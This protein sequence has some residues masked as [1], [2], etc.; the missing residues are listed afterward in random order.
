MPAGMYPPAAAVRAVREYRVPAVAVYSYF[1]FFLFS[2]F[3][4]AGVV[5]TWFKLSSLPIQP[6]MFAL[7]CAIVIPFTR[8]KPTH[9]YFVGAWIFWIIFTVGGFLGPHPLAG[10]SDK[11]LWELVIKL[12]ISLVGVPY[13]TIRAIDR[14]KLSVLVKVAVLAAVV[15]SLFSMLQVVRPGPFA[16]LMAE[17][18]RGAGFWVNPNSC[19][20][21]VG[22]CL[23]LSLAF[24]FKSKLVNLSVRGILALGVLSTLSRTGLLMLVIGFA[25]YG[26]AAKRVRTVV[27]VGLVLLGV[28][29]V[30]SVMV[31]YL[32]SSGSKAHASR[33]ARFGAML[34]GDFGG[35]QGQQNDRIILWRYGWRAIM[36]EPLLGQ[37]H[38]YMDKVVPIATGFGPH[39][40]YIYV[41]GNSGFLAFLAF[42][43]FL[44][45]LVLLSWR[46]SERQSCAALL[47]IAA[48][49]LR[50][51]HGGS[52][53]SRQPVLRPHLCHHGHDRLLPEA[54]EKRGHARHGGADAHDHAGSYHAAG[55]TRWPA[56]HAPLALTMDVARSPD[57]STIGHWLRIPAFAITA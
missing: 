29:V 11:P 24:P 36:Q 47:A 8:S 40:Y 48:M 13:L 20:L 37:G 51:G 15:G 38:R 23:F 1:F 32:Q 41:W 25:V 26:V 45:S 19:A 53:L 5:I 7:T 21:V 12:W 6:V 56:F 35:E 22:F 14:N 43:W 52:L 39:N 10:V 16:V 44:L 57:T 33:L 9:S 4:V 17:P 30:G 42:D 18:G 55:R 34:Q 46:C 2:F 31:N 3:N 28:A 50:R 54:R 49:V 27:Q